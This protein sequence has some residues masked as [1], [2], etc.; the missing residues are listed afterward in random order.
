MSRRA[1]TIV[2]VLVAITLM[3]LVGVTMARMLLVNSRYASRQN[4]MLDSRQ[5]ARAALNQMAAELRMV[6]DSG[7]LAASAKSVQVRIPYASGMAC[8]NT[9]LSAIIASL[10]PPD[11]LLY[12]QALAWGITWRDT[13][14][15]YTNTNTKVLSVTV[16]AASTAADSAKCTVDG[17]RVVPGGKLV[18][19]SNLSKLPPG[20]TILFLFNTVTYSFANSTMFP[21]RTGLYRLQTNGVN[22]ELV[23]P[24][25]TSAGFG[26]ATGP[27]L[28][29]SSTAPANLG[30][31]RGLELKLIGASINTPIGASAPQKFDLR[32][33]VLFLNRMSP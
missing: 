11:S 18:K 26:F 20:G 19:I 2:E 21:G 7:V 25:D 28:A 32:T 3:G 33:T 9:S 15:Y 13:T 1:F 30:S 8:E 5:A 4:A 17:I 22:T 27:T 23:A 16:A 29:I 24:F 6:L 14:G 10:S 31:I 12:A